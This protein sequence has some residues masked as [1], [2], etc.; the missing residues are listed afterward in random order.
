M[1]SPSAKSMPSSPMTSDTFQQDVEIERG[2]ASEILRMALQEGLC[3]ATPLVTQEAEEIPFGDQLGGCV[4]LRHDLVGDGMDPHL[5]PFLA[6]LVARIGDAT[7]QRDHA[8]L[9]QQNSIERHLVEAI[10]YLACCARLVVA[11]DGVDRND[12]RVLRCTFTHQRG[13][14]RVAGIA[15]VPI[16]LAIDF[17]GL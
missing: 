3:G 15:T 17:Y 9:F 1:S 2:T 10:E 6:F 4:Q 13:D 8:Q 11:L 16:G 5:G 14:G 7:Q 12:D